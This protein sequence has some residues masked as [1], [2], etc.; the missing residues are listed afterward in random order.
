VCRYIY[1]LVCTGYSSKLRTQNDYT[2]CDAG[3]DKPKKAGLVI[4]MNLNVGTGL[5]Y[6]QGW[7]PMVHDITQA[8]ILVWINLK[9]PD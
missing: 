8:G 6:R 3:P 2:G 4:Q 1:T 9:R 7:L 5:L